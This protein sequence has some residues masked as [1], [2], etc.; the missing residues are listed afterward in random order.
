MALED[1][2]KQYIPKENK[3]FREHYHQ[4]IL[5]IMLLLIAILAINSL[6]LYQLANRP[7]PVF[8]AATPDGK[9]MALTPYDLPNIQPDVITNFAAKAATIAYSFDFANYREQINSARPFFT[10]DGWND[11]LR[12]VDPVVTEIVNKQLA[13]NAVVNGAPVINNQGDLKLNSSS[14]SPT[15]NPGDVHSPTYA[16]RVA[17]PLIVTYQSA[18][19]L[20]LSR[21][22][23][24]VVTIIKVPT[25]VS[26]MGIGIDQLVMYPMSGVTIGG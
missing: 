18:S 21:N 4:I 2:E 19:Q 7:L 15:F 8:S 16:W 20:P 5:G 1:L 12:A 26:A 14:S 13:V 23:L 9:T 11:F 22:F 3:F 6:L 17:V 25:S 24:V 10:E